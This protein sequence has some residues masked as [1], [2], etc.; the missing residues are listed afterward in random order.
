MKYTLQYRIVET[1][2]PLK[3]YF[4][5][6]T[7]GKRYLSFTRTAE[8]QQ[9]ITTMWLDIHV[10]EGDFDSIMVQREI[11]PEAGVVP[12]KEMTN[13]DTTWITQ[14]KQNGTTF[15]IELFECSDPVGE[16]FVAID[17]RGKYFRATAYAE[18]IEEDHR[19]VTIVPP[20]RLE[21]VVTLGEVLRLA[22][23]AVL[24]FAVVTFLAI[25]IGRYC[26]VQRMVAK[27]HKER[28]EKER[29]D[30]LAAADYYGEEQ[31]DE[32]MPEV[33]TRKVRKATSSFEARKA[34]E[35]RLEQEVIRAQIESEGLMRGEEKAVY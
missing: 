16:Y 30:A 2:I 24:G 3:T 25:R 19:C 10:E 22:F 8:H 18:V 33:N 6:E 15:R 14:W 29:F 23:P 32:S 31:P 27:R 5:I 11:C 1:L 13:N 4:Q 21:I 12:M 26:Y 34:R 17:T 20:F 28:L 35:K 9:K 7:Y